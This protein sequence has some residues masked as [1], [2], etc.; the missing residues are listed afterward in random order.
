[1]EKVSQITED[2]SLLNRGCKLL[3]KSLLLL[4]IECVLLMLFS[5]FGFLRSR[6]FSHC[7]YF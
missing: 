1:M 4:L 2:D 5:P 3:R 6:V 7:P